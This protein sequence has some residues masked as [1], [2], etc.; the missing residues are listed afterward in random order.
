MIKNGELQE[1]QGLQYIKGFQLCFI[2][3]TISTI[4]IVIEIGSHWFLMKL[5]KVDFMYFILFFITCIIENS[6][7]PITVITFC[8]Q[9]GSLKELFKCK[10]DIFKRD[11]TLMR[12]IPIEN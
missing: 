5:K 2:F 8:Y 7:Y 10:K 12:L 6:I 3:V 11:S 4:S 9:K 1:S